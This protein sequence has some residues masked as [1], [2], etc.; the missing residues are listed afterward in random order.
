[1]LDKI[2]L[3]YTSYKEA[4][5]EIN[6]LQ[7][8]DFEKTDENQVQMMNVHPAKGLE[9][10]HVYVVGA[11]D[12]V[13]PSINASKH[14]DEEDDEYAQNNLEEERRIF[15]VALSRAK[16]ELLISSPHYIYRNGKT[17]AYHRTM[18]LH[19]KD[20]LLEVKKI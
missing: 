3:E 10:G 8:T 12:G 1:M 6:I 17:S 13:M 14:L 5:S 2:M 4:L 7:E 16:D 19:G 9:F 11:V 20:H 15:Y 18:F